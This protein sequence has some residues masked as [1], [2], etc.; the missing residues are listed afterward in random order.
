MHNGNVRVLFSTQYITELILMELNFDVYRAFC[1]LVFNGSE[2]INIAI[3]VDC[4]TK[5][6][7]I[8]EQGILL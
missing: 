8:I 2:C 1:R 7:N 6:G 5:E 3:A 4:I